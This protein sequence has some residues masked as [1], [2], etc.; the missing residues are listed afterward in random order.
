MFIC[1]G[2]GCVS[3]ALFFIAVDIKIAMWKGLCG[4]KWHSFRS[5]QFQGP[6]KSRFSRPIP[7]NGRRNEFARISYCEDAEIVLYSSRD[8]VHLK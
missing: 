3:Y 6:K 7:S 8:G 2:S 5:L 4:P 1:T